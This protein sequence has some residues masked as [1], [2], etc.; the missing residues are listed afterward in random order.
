MTPIRHALLLFASLL[1]L[2]GLA[3]GGQHGRK[4]RGLRAELGRA[5]SPATGRANPFAGQPEA[6]LAGKKLFLRH[7]A[8]CHGQDGLCC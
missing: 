1:L 5:P 6:V 7:C 2:G 8:E 4:P 3:L